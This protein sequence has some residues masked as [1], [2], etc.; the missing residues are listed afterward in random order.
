[1]ALASELY[2]TPPTYTIQALAGSDLV[3]DG[4]LASHAFVSILEGVCGDAAGNIYVADADDNRIRKIDA[5]GI[6]TTYAGTGFAG[7]GGD[8]GPATQAALRSPFGIRMDANG[9]LFIA[10][11][12]N[13]RI[14]EVASN[15][16][17][18]TYAS[19][20]NQPRNLALSA[21]GAIFVSEFGAN[22]VSRINADG[23]STPFAG[24]GTAGYAG[25]GGTALAAEMNS[26]AGIAFNTA[27]ALLIADSSNNCI[28]EVTPNG[29]ITTFLGGVG[30]TTVNNFPLIAPTGLAT[31]TLGNI[32]VASL[33]Y[34]STFR[35]DASGTRYTLSGIGRDIYPA[36]NGDVLLVGQQHLEEVHADNS[37]TTLFSSS[38][39]TFGDGGP[40]TSARFESVSGVAVDSQDNVVI[41]DS[42]FR[43]LR[44]VTPTGTIESLESSDF[45]KSPHALAFDQ[46]DR[47]YVVDGDSIDLVGPTGP[48]TIFATSAVAPAGIAFNPQSALYYTDGSQ[49]F[50]TDSGGNST[51]VALNPA[52]VNPTGVAIDA[53]G[54]VYVADTSSNVIR[55][56]AA[57]GTDTVV[58]GN[59][60]AGFGGDEGPASQSQVNAPAGIAIDKGGT[61]WIAD[62][63]N[64]RIRFVDASGTI[65][66]A[67]GNGTA[68][69]SGD[70]GAGLSAQM[71]SPT[72]IACDANGN[73]FFVD[74]GNKRVRE[75]TV[76][77]SAPKAIPAALTV[78]HSATFLVGPI[79]GGEIVT[80]FG[81]NLGPVTALGA[82]LDSS[83]KVST[84]LG[85]TQVL[86]NGVPA[87][88]Y[89]VQA[90]QI[91]A[92]IPIETAGH[93]SVLIEAQRGGVTQ[94]S[95]VSDVTPY[96][97]GLF[98]VN[99]MAAALNY[100]DYSFNS[101]THPA[102]GGSVILLFGTGFGTT[103]PLETTGVPA[104]AP[105]GVPIAPVSVLI[106]NS[107]AQVLYAG[108][109]PGFAGL[110]QLNVVI[111]AGTP[112]GQVPVRVGMRDV[113]SPSGISIQ[114][115]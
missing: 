81:T 47:L 78:T 115:R 91:N 49:T 100:P 65:H 105:F 18:T 103:N 80:L 113:V 110:T 76:G 70:G 53:A 10:D 69:F 27:G 106:G 4:G 64:N 46:S 75:L 66:S 86:V 31:D 71:E 34:P 72:A 90:N 17:I 87:P 101:A 6:V 109:A 104:V 52:L 39:Y 92:E 55:K 67:A 88:L 8:G 2:A 3:G 15:G 21:S 36:V 48:P 99:N 93:L 85:D 22:R 84:M 108:D 94:S 5:A 40:A 58:A 28:R 30:S 45:L 23:S 98:E 1:M 54:V 50:S 107:P 13:G 102:D 97:P 43:R 51:A 9:N 11:L 33:G 77:V 82:T 19:G 32:Y 57:D 44:E 14:R 62:K 73:V 59:G 38:A 42:T 26:P 79:A 60:T 24:N 37:V 112:S 12:G 25:D 56:I 89:Y 35:L 96:S 74:S 83:G 20:L 63:G 114:V 7:F 29:T 95:V 16:V 111:P 68:G 61:L 41:A